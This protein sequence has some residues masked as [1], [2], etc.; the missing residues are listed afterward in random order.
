L[1]LLFFYLSY[2]A[3]VAAIDD[4]RLADQAGALLAAVGAV[5]VPIIWPSPRGPSATK[6]RV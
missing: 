3:L 4:T 2:M 1:I 5:N 6:K